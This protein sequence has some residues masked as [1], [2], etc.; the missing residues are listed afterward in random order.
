[1]L[2]FSVKVCVYPSQS[3]VVRVEPKDRLVF[4]RP[5]VPRIAFNAISHYRQRQRILLSEKPG[6]GQSLAAGPNRLIGINT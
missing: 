3:C 5:I 4:L 2:G 6:E 1:M